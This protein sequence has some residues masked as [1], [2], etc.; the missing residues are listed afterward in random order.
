METKWKV[1]LLTLGIAIPAFLFG[2]GSPGGEALWGTIWPFE[3]PGDGME[4]TSAQLPLFMVLGVFEAVALGLA[5]S[6]LIW[7]LP[8]ARKVAAGSMPRAVGLTVAV[9]WMLGNWWVHDNL[10]IQNGENM[11]GLLVIEYAFHVTLI[12]AAAFAA[13]VLVRS[14]AGLGA[15]PAPS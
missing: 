6:F 7:G 11:W 2:G 15:A 5:I 3:A 13:Y 12:I 9:S 10:H 1:T 14:Y 4:P 8:L